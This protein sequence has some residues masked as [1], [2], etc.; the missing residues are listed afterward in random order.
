MEQI[1]L[2][3]FLPGSNGHSCEL[4]PFGGGNSLVLNRDDC[5]V[6]MVLRLCMLVSNELACYTIRDDGADGCH[7]CFTSHEFA[8]GEN[9][10]L[11]DGAIVRQRQHHHLNVAE[12]NGQWWESFCLC[13]CCLTFC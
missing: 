3:R 9:G 2:V 6:G 8:A 11:L 12:M 1:V 4:H 13:S 7:V 5:G 10:R